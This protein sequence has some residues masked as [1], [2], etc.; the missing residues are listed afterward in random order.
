MIPSLIMH[1]TN[2]ASDR[3]GD[4]YQ[5]MRLLRSFVRHMIVEEQQR[6]TRKG[7]NDIPDGWGVVISQKGKDFKVSLVDDQANEIA[8][9]SAERSGGSMGAAEG[10]MAVGCSRSHVKG[11]GPLVYDVAMEWATLQ[12][13]GL[14]PDREIVSDE[15]FRVWQTYS[16]ARAD[17][18][19]HQ[20]D[21]M[22]NTLTPSA[23]D[24]VVQIST[25][26]HTKDGFKHEYEL[27]ADD[28]L[29]SP[30]AKRYTK[31]SSMI[32]A[33]RRIG[34]LHITSDMH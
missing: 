18:S 3:T 8:R 1:L 12:A 11:W 13:N 14:M 15:A 21:S 4:T 27:T 26:D 33:L 6:S 2:A 9:V 24:N 10:A 34:K 19:K 31:R 32:D 20:L 5:A 25:G 17:V 28:L 16:D 23:S 30:L 7:P 29:A 22:K